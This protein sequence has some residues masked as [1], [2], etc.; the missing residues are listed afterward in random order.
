[1]PRLRLQDAAGRRVKA[2][3]AALRRRHEQA[4]VRRALERLDDH[5]LRDIGVTRAEVDAGLLPPFARPE[6]AG[7][8]A[9]GR[10]SPDA[11]ETTETQCRPSATS[12]ETDVR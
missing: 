9:L 6:D 12:A 1:M 8:R 3:L 5:L 11:G 4:R 2:T 10:T 7:V